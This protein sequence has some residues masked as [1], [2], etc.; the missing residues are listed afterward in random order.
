MG[1][2]VKWATSGEGKEQEKF[3]KVGVE[4][5]GL[6]G[7]QKT[8]FE[9]IIT[10]HKCKLTVMI[11]LH[12]I[13]VVVSLRGNQEREFSNPSDWPTDAMFLWRRH[14]ELGLQHTYRMAL[15]CQSENLQ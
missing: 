13:A 10:L 4:F 5:G 9:R 14:K 1:K 12:G 8:A 15:E 3:E 6:L 7:C 2:N 11:S